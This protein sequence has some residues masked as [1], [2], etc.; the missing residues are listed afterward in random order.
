MTLLPC[1]HGQS[2][3]ATTTFSTVRNVYRRFLYRRCSNK[4]LCRRFI[5]RKFLYVVMATVYEPGNYIEC[6]VL[7]VDEEEIVTRCFR[8]LD[9]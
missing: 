5:Y 9:C 2:G 6:S 8:T 4:V 1:R 7:S 3:R